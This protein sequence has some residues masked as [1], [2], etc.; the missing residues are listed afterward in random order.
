MVAVAGD[1][2]DTAAN[3]VAAATNVSTIVENDY[4]VISVA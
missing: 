2:E 4:P 1:I 3:A